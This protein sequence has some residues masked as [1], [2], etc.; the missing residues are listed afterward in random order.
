MAAMAPIQAQIR[1]TTSDD[2]VT[3]SVSPR[4]VNYES[5]DIYGAPRNRHDLFP[6]A[7]CLGWMF[8]LVLAF[9]AFVLS[10]CTGDGVV[11]EYNTAFFK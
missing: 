11:V 10:G 8:F 7:P 6:V 3:R 4:K 9:S 5:F 1:V 2:P